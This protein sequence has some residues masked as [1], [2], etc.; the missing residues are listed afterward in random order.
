VA[1]LGGDEFAVL[2]EDVADE[3]EAVGFAKRFL[4]QLRAPLDLREYQLYATASIGIAIGSEETPEE[5]VRAADLAMYRVK[6]SGKTHI[7]VS[8]PSM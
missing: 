8:D 3:S 7:V 2:L 6:S 5:L 1:R 4:R